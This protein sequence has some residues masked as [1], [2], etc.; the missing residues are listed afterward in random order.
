MVANP[1]RFPFKQQ[2]VFLIALLAVTVLLT[3]CDFISEK[4]VEMAGSAL[5]TTY[6]IKIVDIPKGINSDQLHQQ[7]K[8]VITGVDDAM[9]VHNPTS[10]IAQFNRSTKLDWFKPTPNLFLVI[11]ESLAI[12]KL[13]QGA[14]DVT[15]GN[16]IEIWGF[17][18]TLPPDKIPE[19]AEIDKA[20][21]T[22]GYTKLQISSKDSSIRKTD[23]GLTINL[24]AIAKGFAVD[25][26]AGFLEQKGIQRFLV[27]IGGEI[28][29]KGYKQND[30]PWMVA[31][32]RP[33]TDKR[34]I[35]KI[36]RL[37]GLS[38]ATS[39]DYR[40]FYEIEGK[41]Y[42]HT[43]NPHT[44]KPVENNIASVSVLH[45]SC[46]TADAMATALMSLGYEKGARFAEERGLSV[47]WI[48]RTK[49]GVVEK[50]SEQ[51]D[52]TLFQ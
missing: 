48:L 39:G 30:K 5:G 33:E 4:P 42:A 8:S 13:S 19:T 49:N 14:F 22:A 18:K 31:I 32:E 20:R 25:S 26:V 52:R 3:A 51:F 43:I 44:G 35:Y 29:T 50:L 47:L 38:M 10:E 41:R 40:N 45:E 1:V 17:G 27:E 23:P 2:R 21:Q 34:S 7:I 6:S 9:S 28:R 15:I 16:L 37:S 24:S 46:M 12:S 36:I 11:N